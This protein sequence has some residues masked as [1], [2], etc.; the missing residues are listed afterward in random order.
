MHRGGKKQ[1]VAASSAENCK[2]TKYADLDHS[3]VFIPVAVETMGVW[4]FLIRGRRNWCWLCFVVSSYLSFIAMISF[5]PNPTISSLT[6][7]LIFSSPVPIR[8]LVLTATFFTFLIWLARIKLK[9]FPNFKI[10]GTPWLNWNN[11]ILNNFNFITEF[12]RVWSLDASD[13]LTCFFYILCME[14]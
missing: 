2:I 9:T 3:H 11:S 13:C 6:Y 4:G 12:L 7:S 5:S 10:L 14:K 1:C 8:F